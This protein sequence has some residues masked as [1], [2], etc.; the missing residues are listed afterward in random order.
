[1]G[2]YPDLKPIPPPKTVEQL[3]REQGVWGKK[4]DYRRLIDAAFPTEKDVAEFEA[5]LDDIK[6][7]PS[8]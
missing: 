5:Y 2:D 7:R 4:F 3:A 1:M 6:G 8:E